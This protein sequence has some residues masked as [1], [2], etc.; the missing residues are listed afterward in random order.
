VKEQKV[1][2]DK[3]NEQT[4]FLKIHKKENISC[5]VPGVIFLRPGEC[6]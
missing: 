2:W 1:R 5:L 4:A 6:K 3:V